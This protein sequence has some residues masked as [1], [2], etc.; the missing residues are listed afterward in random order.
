[1][2][3]ISSSLQNTNITSASRVPLGDNGIS[4]QESAPA[5]I[6]DQVEISQADSAAVAADLEA[7]SATE[8]EAKAISNEGEAA[9]STPAK[10]KKKGK[11]LN[12][13]K[14]VKKGMSLYKEARHSPLTFVKDHAKKGVPT[15]I[16]LGLGAAAFCSEALDDEQVDDI[17][18]LAEDAA[19]K[20]GGIKKNI[21]FF[22]KLS[23]FSGLGWPG[24]SQNRRR[25]TQYH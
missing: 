8:A 18:D 14:M 19:N 5:V 20:G 24:P 25:R 22:N 11:K 1:M 13:K 21:E 3:S 23:D 6:N 9:S 12:P 2:I 7:A 17:K 10:A 4:K 15:V 16:I